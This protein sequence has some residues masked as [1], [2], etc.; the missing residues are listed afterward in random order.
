MRTA[1]KLTL[2]FFVIILLLSGAIWGLLYT[3]AGLQFLMKSVVDEVPGLSIQKMEGKWNDL[4]LKGIEYQMSGLEV[5]VKETHLAL[6]FFCQIYRPLCIDKLGIDGLDVVIDTKKR[7]SVETDE[8]PLT[9][10]RIPY[11]L[12]LK[13]LIFSNLNVTIDDTRIFLAHFRTEADW[14]G[15]TLSFSS[16]HISGLLVTLPKTAENKISSIE[17]KTSTSTSISPFNERLHQ[18]PEKFFAE[19]L[20]PVLPDFHFPLDIQIKKL[21]AEQLQIAGDENMIIHSL[22]LQARVHDH[23]LELDDLQVHLPFGDFSARGKATFVDQWPI[24]LRIDSLLKTAPLEKQK[25][26]LHMTGK[27]QKQLKLTADLSGVINARLNATTRLSQVG[28]PVLMTLT[29][30]QL[31][32]PLKG[33]PEYKINHLKW[34]FKGKATDYALSLQGNI[35]IANLPPAVLTLD[36]KG[37]LQQFSLTRLRLALLQG[38]ADLSGVLDWSKAVSW[39]SQLMLKGIDTTKQWPEWPVQLNGKISNRVSIHGDSWQ[40]QIPDLLLEGEVQ[41]RP[42]RISGALKGNMAD[43]WK[44]SSFDVLLGGNKLNITGELSR[45]WALDARIEAPKLEDGLP[46]LAGTLKGTLKLRGD[47][48]KPGLEAHLI[49]QRLK[50]QNLSIHQI[51]LDTSLQ[52]S[53]QIKGKLALQVERLKQADMIVRHLMLSATGT[54]KKHQLTLE[55]KGE[56]VSGGLALQGH[57]NRQKQIWDGRLNKTD[58]RALSLDWHLNRSTGITY[59]H[60]AQK[61]TIQPHCWDNPQAQLCVPDVITAGKS[62]GQAHVQ[63]HQFDVALLKPFLS[64]DTDIFGKITGDAQIKWTPEDDLP[65]AQLSVMGHDIKIRQNIEDNPLNVVF[66]TLKLGGQLSHHQAQISTL[67]SLENNGRIQG[68]LRISDVQ[69][70]RALSGKLDIDQ[71]SLAPVNTVLDKNEK[72]TGVLN[73]HLRISGNSKKPLLYGNILLD[74]FAL[75][76]SWIPVNIT[77]AS[78]LSID[79]EGIQSTLQ[80]LIATPKGEITLSGNANWDHISA[81]KASIS[82]KGER[83]RVTFP[84]MVKLDISPDIRFEATPELLSLK[85]LVEIPWARIEVKDIPP[86]VVKVSSH[87]VMLNDQLQP[88]LPQKAHIPIYTDVNI[89]VGKDVSMDAFGLQAQLEGRLNVHQ[90]Q[91]GIQLKGQI[92]I[93]SGSFRAYGQDLLV[94]KGILLFSGPMKPLLDIEAIRNPDSITSGYTAG[95]RVTGNTDAPKIEIFSNPSLSQQEALSYLL[96]GHGL[97]Q[98]GTDSGLM[99]SMLIGIGISQSGNLIGKI[100]GVFGISDLA[101]D[102]QGVG[103]KSQVVVSGYLTK[104]LQ[105]KYGVG[106]FDSLATLTLRYQL[107]PR[108]YLEGISGID[109]ALDLLYQFE[110]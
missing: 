52:S 24:A 76:G 65:A 98:S 61:V 89:H 47:L 100:G 88:V 6:N 79:L 9:D 18:D 68:N 69:G 50:W 15:R 10:I 59:F 104:K 108:L 103:E 19:P 3:T 17:A 22:S 78:H 35:N 53:D 97:D 91:Q 55:L 37:N 2:A 13:N 41:Q 74:R 14:H 71:I 4:T 75:N 106:I 26:Q 44:I 1:K 94:K 70:N 40:W 101:L 11:P 25:I 54:E 62:G 66:D 63:L 67:I 49:A 102:T 36:G 110:F 107:M 32:W 92:N 82:A 90:H 21:T 46:G 93:P 56:P 12:F 7:P 84:P 87:E 86:D 30:P 109:Q 51:K 85:G 81:W 58:I 83:V 72:I 29:A 96:R 48:H 5:K 64:P 95:I 8:E 39:H 80:G 27:L 33:K 99:T 38:Q 60:H 20:L 73:S 42:F 34:R 105:V 45:Q 77:S 16:P 43:Q 57:F 28:L 23:R 31:Q